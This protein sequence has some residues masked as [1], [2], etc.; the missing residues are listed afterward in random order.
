MKQYVWITVRGAEASYTARGV[1][2]SLDGGTRLVYEEPASLGLGGVTTA[3][4]LTEGR[5]VLTRS[6]AVR[7]E[8]RFE[9]GV[10]HSSLYETA[11]GSFPAEVVTHALRARLGAHGGLV[12]LRY[13]LTLGGVPDERRL[14]LLIRT[15]EKG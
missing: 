12:D 10:P 11:H 1:M 9:E 5:A 4:A 13:T 7:S 14:R 2:E 15:E 3:L 6:G 8:L